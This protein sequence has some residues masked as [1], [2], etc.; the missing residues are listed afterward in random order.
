M[1]YMSKCNGVFV[2]SKEAHS[3]ILWSAP[4]LD[5]NLYPFEHGS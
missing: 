4:L 2:D 3:L 1:K 5:N